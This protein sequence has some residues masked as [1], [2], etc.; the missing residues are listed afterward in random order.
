MGSAVKERELREQLVC[1]P[2]GRRGTLHLLCSDVC[3]P[4]RVCDVVSVLHTFPS[5]LRK[6][7]LSP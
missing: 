3:V 1:A 2:W 6:S 7:D 4:S 5:T